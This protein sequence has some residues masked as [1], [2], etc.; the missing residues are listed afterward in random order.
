MTFSLVARDE[1]GAI[2]M[3][4]TSSSPCVGAR[5][6][7]LRSDVGGVASQNITDPRFGDIILDSLASGDDATQALEK[8]LS[9]DSTVAY[10]QITVVDAAGRTAA[11]SG[12]HTLGRNRVVTS[13]GVVAAGNLLSNDSVP[14]RMLEA[15]ESTAGDLEYR[16]LAALAAGEKAGGEEGDIASCGLSVV[17]EAGWRVTDL[18]IDWHPKPIEALGELLDV[19][20]PQRDDYVTRGI[21]PE[22]APSYGVPGDE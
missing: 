22:L 7:H 16:L 18:R 9:H 12:E 6:I 5:C 14:S 20:M 2:G 8:L 13:D 17:R 11:H 19:W 3:V 21:H 15:Y 4:V 10:R 1:S